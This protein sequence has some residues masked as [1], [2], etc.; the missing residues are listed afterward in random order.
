MAIR[1]LRGI[2]LRTLRLKL[3]TAEIAEKLAEF[4]E[5]LD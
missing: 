5:K 3:L 2:A 4:P 1:V